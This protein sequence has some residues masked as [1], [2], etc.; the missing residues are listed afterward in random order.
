MKKTKI[1]EVVSNIINMIFSPLGFSVPAH[2]L[3]HRTKH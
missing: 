1:L 2:Y 3:P